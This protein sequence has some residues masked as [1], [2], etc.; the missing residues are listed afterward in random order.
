M[1]CEWSATIK[2]EVGRLVDL[3]V[4]MST[5]PSRFVITRV[6]PF[7]RIAHLLRNNSQLA[8]SQCLAPV[9]SRERLISRVI[10]VAIV[11]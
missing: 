7:S 1:Y 2:L 8:G 9:N 4:F 5:P 3:T 10:E 11:G 6:M